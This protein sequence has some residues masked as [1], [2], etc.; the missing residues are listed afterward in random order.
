MIETQRLFI[1]PYKISDTHNLWQTIKTDDIYATTYG[2]PKNCDIRYA[3]K[4]IK[5]VIDNGTLGSSYE[6]AIIDKSSGYYVGNVGL[7]NIDQQCK[8]CD[9]SY[10]INPKFKGMGY[11][12]ESAIEMIK[13][14]FLK[15]DMERVGG[16][17]MSH[18]RASARV[19]EKLLMKKEGTMRNYLIKDGKEVSLDIY[20]ILK[21][22]FFEYLNMS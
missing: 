19:M 3:K 17:C 6:Y 20:S 11:A 5:A 22:E 14:A 9:I 13:L 18:N 2:I 8:R 7:I 21:S 4:W 12:T 15:L 1:R 16:T 10:F